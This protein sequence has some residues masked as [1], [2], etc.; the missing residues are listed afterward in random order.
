MSHLK[1]INTVYTIQQ[2][3]DIIRPIV[4]KYDIEKVS[5]F[6]SYAKNTATVKSDIDFYLEGYV[7]HKFLKLGNLFADLEEAFHKHIDIITDLDLKH[8]Q[9]IDELQNN[10]IEEK[11]TVYER[12]KH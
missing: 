3:E 10:I 4:S 7:Y 1:I 12:Q 8:N 6:G 5:V 2:I 9:G 11:V